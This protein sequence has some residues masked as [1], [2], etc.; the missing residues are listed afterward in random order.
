MNYR[1]ES[2][3]QQYLGPKVMRDFGMFALL[4]REKARHYRVTDIHNEQGY[5][6][7]RETLARNHDLSIAEPDIQVV[8]VDLLGDR[9]LMLEAACRNQSVL[10]E[11]DTSAVVEYVSQL[12]GYEVQLEEIDLQDAA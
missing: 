8:D 4:D 11:A 10:A 9:R 7:V 6:N 3:I 2:F 1:D 5:R 12:W